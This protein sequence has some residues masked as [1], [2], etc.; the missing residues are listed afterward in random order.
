MRIL[1]R[2]LDRGIKVTLISK[3]WPKRKNKLPALPK[4]LKGT[5][6]ENTK[7]YPVDGAG[8]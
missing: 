7:K 4:F 5:N 6:R 8:N 3:Q 1:K 2:I